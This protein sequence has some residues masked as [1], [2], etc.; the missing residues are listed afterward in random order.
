MNWLLIF[1][2]FDLLL[3]ILV[4]LGIRGQAKAWATERKLE[5]EK[6]FS[7]AKPTDKIFQKSDVSR[8]PPPVQRYLIKS[9][10]EGTPYTS[11][12]HLKQTGQIRFNQR[13]INVEAEQYYSVTPPNFIWVAKMKLGPAWISARDRYLSG[14]GGML[15]K[16]LSA[17]PL[18]DVRGPEI[19]HA[20][21]LRYLSE[22]P[23]LPTALLSDNITWKE[24]DDR[25]AEA[26]ITDGALSAAGVFHFNGADE[27]ISFESPGRFRSDT[28]K[29]TPWS[30][31]FSNY[32]DFNGFRIPAEGKA[33]WNAPEGDFEYVR[34]KVE[35]AEFK[36]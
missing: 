11:R 22:L 10:R 18:F 26:T 12:V 31:A 33:V 29:I 13:W 21:L 4:A 5:I 15:I 1:F 3:G 28:G 2:A 23:W 34:L 17:V 14:K 30:G 6:L 24:I 35:K 27:I 36:A 25:A 9:I 19:D 7:T 20:S 16:V 32:Q 8:L